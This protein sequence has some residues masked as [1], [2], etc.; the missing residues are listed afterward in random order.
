MVGFID[1]EIVYS[2]GDEPTCVWSAS[3]SAVACRTILLNW[4]GNTLTK[5]CC[6]SLESMVMATHGA[7]WSRLWSM[8]T[9]NLP[10]C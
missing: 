7:S 4:Q 10:L 2:L 5:V 6:G 8:E 9:P 1:I 3:D